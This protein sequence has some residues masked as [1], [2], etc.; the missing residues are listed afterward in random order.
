LPTLASVSHEDESPGGRVPEQALDLSQ[1][2]VAFAQLH[3]VAA[4]ASRD[5]SRGAMQAG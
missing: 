5:P 1:E 4:P 2:C 3:V